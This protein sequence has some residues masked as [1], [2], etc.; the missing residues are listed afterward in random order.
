M[1]KGARK[2]RRQETPAPDAETEA[3]GVLTYEEILITI[4]E[5]SRGAADRCAQ[6]ADVARLMGVSKAA[7]HNR[8][9][10]LIQRGLLVKDARKKLCFTPE[11]LETTMGLERDFAKLEFH[12]TQAYGLSRSEARTC[13]FALV[14]VLPEAGRRRFIHS[15]EHPGESAMDAYETLGLREDAARMLMDQRHKAGDLME[16]AERLEL[17]NETLGDEAFYLLLDEL[18]ALRREWRSLRAEKEGDPQGALQNPPKE[19]FLKWRYNQSIERY[20]HRK[21]GL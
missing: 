1:G 11:G 8:I 21:L 19:T 20:Y 10:R 9:L 14:A 15:V 7:M 18:A 3:R 17:L 2:P 6:S 4:L 13:V 16:D 12:Y 5:L